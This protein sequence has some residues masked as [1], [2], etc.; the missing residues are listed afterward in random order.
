MRRIKYYMVKIFISALYI[1]FATN[2]FAQ[3]TMLNGDTLILS[4]DAKFWLNEELIFG[5][6]TMPDRSYT[7]I[8]EAPNSLQKLVNNRKRKLLSPG[9]KGFKSKIVKFEK[10]IGH[11]KKEYDYTILVLEM[12]NGTKYWCDVKNA[13]TNHE[14][15]L[16]TSENN[17]APVTKSEPDKD[18]ANNLNKKKPDSQKTTSKKKTSKSKATTIF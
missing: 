13:Y 2:L 16:K 15:V 10:E 18:D 1:L 7:Y 12:P 8:Y 6:G 9:Y 4:K 3:H 11:N 5:S 14:I 17:G